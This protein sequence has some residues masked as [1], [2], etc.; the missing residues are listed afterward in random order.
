VTEKR[1]ETYWYNEKGVLTRK[2]VQTETDINTYWYPAE[3]P[4]YT[5][6]TLPWVHPMTVTKVGTVVTNKTE[7]ISAL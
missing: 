1:T 2:Q 7:H 6:P 3:S 4:T 5:A